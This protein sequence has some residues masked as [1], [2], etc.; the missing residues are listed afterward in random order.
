MTPED[1]DLASEIRAHIEQR[2]DDLVRAGVPRSEA[3]RRARIEFGSVERYREETREA[4][5]PVGVLFDS[6]WRDVVFATRRLRAAPVFTTFAVSSLAIGLGITVAAYSVLSLLL[7]PARGLADPGR[8]VVLQGGRAID[9]GHTTSRADFDD[10]VQSQTTMTSVA[11]WTTAGSSY[12][13]GDVAERFRGEAVSGNAFEVLG[14]RMAR[15]RPI[16]PSD[17][18]ADA[19]AVVVLSHAFWTRQLRSDPQ[20]VGRVARIGGQPFEVI[21]V[22]DRDLNTIGRPDLDGRTGW[23]PLEALRRFSKSVPPAL[24][25]VSRRAEALSVI[26]RLH[27]GRTIDDARAELAAIGA[28]L[29][30]SAPRRIPLDPR[31]GR[32]GQTLPR[33]WSAL[34]ADVAFRVSGTAL[35]WLL[36]ALVALVLLVA[37]TNIANLML[38]RGSTR[39][40]EIGVRRALGASRSRLVR[41]L[42]VEAAVIATAGGAL[43]L[44]VARLALMIIAADIMP[45]VQFH[46]ET[47][48]SLDVFVAAGLGL[49][50]TTAVF[51]LWPAV[52]LTRQDPRAAL[53]SNTGTG[54]I[55]WR[56]RRSLIV[57][58]VAVSAGFLLFAAMCT[59][60]LLSETRRGAG[61]VDIGRLAI[62]T[63]RFP[64]LAFDE[65]RTRLAV[66]R[67]L[68]VVGRHPEVESAA[69]TTGFPVAFTYSAALTPPGEP[70]QDGRQDYPHARF[71]AATPQIFTT[72]GLPVVEGRGFD[73]RDSAAAP[74]VAVLAELTAR[75]VFGTTRVVGRQLLARVVTYGA[76]STPVP[77]TV[78]GVVADAETQP[79]S[80]ENRGGL[81]VPLA[82]QLLP[83]VELVVRTSGDPSTLLLPLRT[84]VRQ[85]DPD[86]FAERSVTGEYRL[87]PAR[88][89]MRYF[90][91][92]GGVLGVVALV[93]AMAG[94]SGVLL[95]LV[96]RRSREMGVRLALGATPSALARLVIGDGLRPVLLGLYLG[97]PAG[98][99]G[100]LALAP[101]ARLTGSPISAPVLLVVPLVLLA[102]A[103]VAC[104]LPAFRASRVDPNVALREN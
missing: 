76:P 63:I 45:G 25:R 34:G 31:T 18:R 3:E 84:L 57:G 17:D 83:S 44:V 37:C 42:L 102:S 1:D 28:R 23:I 79:R 21:G 29:D 46:L 11:A 75:E 97:L 87:D 100:W 92:A 19:N 24:D 69:V 77:L 71:I 32:G 12:I 39:R 101:G 47:T 60:S 82:Q 20:V 16:R 55:R 61:R 86:L 6:L 51:G 66:D 30:A 88:W 99:A 72:I 9:W 52:N 2:T 62:A 33:Q 14:I 53:A 54:A 85:A 64:E 103:A 94:L 68:D 10:L 40:Q 35:V 93:L 81:F 67:V 98:L 22:A 56:T 41:E 36:V 74:P 78:V 5:R 4:S 91:F 59:W 95:H 89:G 26:G 73:A 90:G 65:Q 96:A 13:D 27:A 70:F 48:L 104:Y 49:A 58:Q 50:I 80:R 8:L 43:A 15:G 7:W 38:A